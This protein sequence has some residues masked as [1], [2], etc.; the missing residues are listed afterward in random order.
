MIEFA[1]TILLA[2]SFA[3]VVFFGAYI[4]CRLVVLSH[5]WINKERSTWSLVNPHE[6]KQRRHRVIPEGFWYEVSILLQDRHTVR[7]WEIGEES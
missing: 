1:A 4:A 2:V 5:T 6:E 3:T 7:A